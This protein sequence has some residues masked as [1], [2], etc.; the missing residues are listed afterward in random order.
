M[1][2]IV[3]YFSRSGNTRETAT[4]AAKRTSSDI[5]ELMPPEPLPEDLKI[6]H[7]KVVEE[8]LFPS[9]RHPL[10]VPFDADKYAVFIVG[11]PLWIGTYPEF[12]M[13]YLKS[14]DWRGRKVYPFIS[15]GGTRGNYYEKLQ[16][17]C[18]GAVVDH[19]LEMHGNKKDPQ[20]ARNLELWLDRINNFTGNV[21]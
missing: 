18:K 11:A 5:I 4:L 2:S 6:L 21:K 3:V 12:F 17:I 13:D 14:I 7:D 16:E 10:K 8:K 20:E 19:P 1:K 15:F 9:E